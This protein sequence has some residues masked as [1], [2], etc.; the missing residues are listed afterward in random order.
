ML[1]PR[2]SPGPPRAVAWRGGGEAPRLWVPQGG[3]LPSSHRP[4]QGPLVC[5]GGSPR[6][7]K[8]FWLCPLWAGGLPGGASLGSREAA[9]QHWR[10]VWL[11]SNR[12]VKAA[13]AGQRCFSRQAGLP[14][15]PG[16]ATAGWDLVLFSHRPC[17]AS[18]TLCSL[19]DH[20]P[21]GRARHWAHLTSCSGSPLPVPCLDGDGSAACGRWVCRPPGGWG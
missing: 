10:A 17:W 6:L 20:S 15:C 2:A 11:C 5:V 4:P 9:G 8:S 1:R 3:L 18:S 19:S 13:G 7:S 16:G 21:E 12:G 14:W